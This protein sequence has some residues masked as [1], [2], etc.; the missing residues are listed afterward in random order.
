MQKIRMRKEIKINN[1]DKK[2]VD[3][4]PGYRKVKR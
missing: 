2:K 3:G 1:G 4:T